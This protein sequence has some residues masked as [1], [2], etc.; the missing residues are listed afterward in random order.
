MK[1]LIPVVLALATACAPVVV[2]CYCDLNAPPDVDTFYCIDD[3][4]EEVLEE[5]ACAEDQFCNVVDGDD[6]RSR[7]AVCVDR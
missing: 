3:Y 2:Q 1:V 7:V 5:G 6:G 4:T